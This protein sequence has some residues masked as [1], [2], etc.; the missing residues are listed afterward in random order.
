M[1]CSSPHGY[2]RSLLEKRSVDQIDP[3]GSKER[4]FLWRWANR[5][6][7]HQNLLS[8]LWKYGGGGSGGIVH[9]GD[10]HIW[11]IKLWNQV[12]DQKSVNKRRK[13]ARRCSQCRFSFNK[14]PGESRFKILSLFFFLQ[15][16]GF[17][18][19]LTS[20]ILSYI[21]KFNVGGKISKRP[22]VKWSSTQNESHAV[23]T[24]A[25]NTNTSR[26]TEEWLKREEKFMC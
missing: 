22:P 12:L 4:S 7:K 16:C 26:S 15:Y 20:W 3:F 14:T 1:V 17:E 19:A 2:T 18:P 11:N 8:H 24:T 6:S 13:P 5:A 25:T 23:Q 9:V 10:V 21:S